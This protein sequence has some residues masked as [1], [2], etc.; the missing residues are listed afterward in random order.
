MTPV[1]GAVVLN[2]PA[3][4]RYAT[5]AL[6][7]GGTSASSTSRAPTLPVRPGA[8]PLA[9]CGQ[10]QWHHFRQHD[11]VVL[12]VFWPIRIGTNFCDYLHWAL[13]SNALYVGCNMFSNAGSFR[14]TNGYV[15]RKSSILGAG[16]YHS[17]HVCEYGVGWC[18]LRAICTKGVSTI[19]TPQPRK[20]TSSALTTPRSAP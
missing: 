9:A 16:P 18:G 7:G 1:A 10:Q 2:S 13:M 20:G 17:D 8:Q 11:L 4:H 6:R 14:G 19:T 3:T 15:I 12:S 5:T